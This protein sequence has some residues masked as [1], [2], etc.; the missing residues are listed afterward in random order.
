MLK[1]LDS[2]SIDESEKKNLIQ[3]FKELRFESD[4]IKSL[5]PINVNIIKDH[6]LNK[7]KRNKKEKYK[8]DYE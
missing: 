1:A 8:R 2:N 3:S 6:V 7:K 4:N 5:P